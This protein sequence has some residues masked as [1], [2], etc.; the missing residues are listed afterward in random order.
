MYPLKETSS[1]KPANMSERFSDLFTMGQFPSNIGMF[2]GNPRL[3]QYLNHWL[4]PI[5]YVQNWPDIWTSDWDFSQMSSDVYYRLNIWVSDL[6]W[7]LRMPKADED[8]FEMTV[9]V[10]EKLHSQPHG[11]GGKL[12]STVGLNIQ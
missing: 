10:Q 4:R 5:M 9:N 8:V 7:Y 3:V 2:D 1:L 11:P 12:S 6:V